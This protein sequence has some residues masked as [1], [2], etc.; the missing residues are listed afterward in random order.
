M[1]LFYSTRFPFLMLAQHSSISE[2]M[3]GGDNTIRI[4]L[5]LHPFSPYLEKG[6]VGM[7]FEIHFLPSH[8]NIIYIIE[9]NMIKEE[10]LH[11]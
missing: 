8:R 11:N 1:D 5:M 3:H 6:K 2:L 7:L 9:N 4:I 10:I